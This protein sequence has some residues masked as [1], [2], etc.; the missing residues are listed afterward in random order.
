MVSKLFKHL[1][2]MGI[3]CFKNKCY[4]YA[5]KLPSYVDLHPSTNIK[6][7]RT[8]WN[9]N[10]L[11]EIS[12]FNTQNIRTCLVKQDQACSYMLVAVKL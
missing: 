9:K 4:E 1:D 5:N 12:N 8:Q 2:L 11:A 6:Y 7:S 3:T 10:L